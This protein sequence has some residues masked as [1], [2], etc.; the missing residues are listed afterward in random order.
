MFSNLRGVRRSTSALV[1]A[2]AFL[3]SAPAVL[4]QAPPAQ[5]VIV[6]INAPG[7]GFNDPTPAVPVGGNA[8]TTLG[9]QRLN[10]FRYAAEL[11]GRRISSPVPI[12][13]RAQFTPLG[14]G[15]LGSAGPVSVVRDFANAP[16]PGTWYHVALANALAGVDLLPANDDI[17]ANFSTT[18]ISISGSTTRHRPRRTTSLRCCCTSSPM[19]SASASWPT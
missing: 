6:N 8:G 19:D 15:V 14:A 13:I 4:A 11:W 7:V 1:A 16:V 9:E 18:S 10:A 2:G 17:N 12:R 5:I 3:T